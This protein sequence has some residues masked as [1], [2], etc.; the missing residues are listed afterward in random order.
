VPAFRWL[1]PRGYHA[2]CYGQIRC[3]APAGES[4]RCSCARWGRLAQVGDQ[5]ARAA[6]EMQMPPVRNALQQ[7]GREAVEAG[8]KPQSLLTADPHLPRTEAAVEAR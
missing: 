3:T 6:E 4:S 5:A 7:G 2:K 8:R 1:L